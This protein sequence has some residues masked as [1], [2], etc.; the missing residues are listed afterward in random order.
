M[1]LKLWTLYYI[2][3]WTNSTSQLPFNTVN[4]VR[5]HITDHSCSLSNLYYRRRSFYSS[6]N[7]Q[8]LLLKETICKLIGTV[9]TACDYRFRIRFRSKKG[10][11]SARA[12]YKYLKPGLENFSF[13]A[14]W[15]DLFQKNLCI[16]KDSRILSITRLLF[17]IKSIV[18]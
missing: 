9:P 12:I 14:F 13:V 4:I 16:F 6:Y 5:F 17:K 8:S 10:M 15:W 7:I 18:T 3:A 11:E 2:R 1:S